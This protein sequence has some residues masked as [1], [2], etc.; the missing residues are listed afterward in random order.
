MFWNCGHRMR[1]FALFVLA[2]GTSWGQDVDLRR[3]LAEA[4]LIENGIERLAAFDGILSKHGLVAKAE[5]DL[6]G[7]GE[8]I[9]SRSTSPI[10]DSKTLRAA[11]FSSNEVRTTAG[12]G[13][14]TLIVRYMEGKLDVYINFENFMGGDAIRATVRF[15]TQPASQE[16]LSISTDHTSGFFTRSRWEVLEKLARSK[17]LLVRATPYSSNPITAEFDLTGF[18]KHFAEFDQSVTGSESR[19]SEKKRKEAAIRAANS[20]WEKSARDYLT[21]LRSD[22]PRYRMDVWIGIAREH[23]KTRPATADETL[24]KELTDA[25]FKVL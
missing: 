3:D 12:M 1:A 2:C 15:D 20:A 24:V 22:H 11:L 7:E 6:G 9:L 19:E 10:D 17:R 16:E 8:W 5:A 4:G 25:V 14:L 23:L 21:E 13:P 18:E